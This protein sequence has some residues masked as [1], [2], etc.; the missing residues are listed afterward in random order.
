MGFL[1]KYGD[2]RCVLVAGV[3]ENDNR[4]ID[5]RPQLRA[6]RSVFFARLAKARLCQAAS[7]RDTQQRQTKPAQPERG[8]RA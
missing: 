2:F 4:S 5:A 7:A 8:D 1:K 3:A 6:P